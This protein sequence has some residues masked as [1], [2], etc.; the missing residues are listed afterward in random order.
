MTS[1]L[2]YGRNAV[3]EALRARRRTLRRLVVSRSVQESGIIADIIRLAEQAGI[4]IERIER[5]ILDRQLRDANHQGVML[6]TGPYPYVELDECL[7]SANARRE[8]ALLLLLDHLQD[9]QNL[10]TL[11]RTAE[12]V[13]CH[14]IIIPGRRAAE[15]TPAVVNASSGAVEHLR[16]AMVTN[17]SQ[18]IEELQHNGIWVV[19]LEQDETAQ[20]IDAVDLNL[21]LGLVIGAEGTGMSRLVR[22]RCD[23]LV[24]L[25]IVGQIGSLNAAVAGS[26]AIYHAWRQ[27]YRRYAE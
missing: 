20:D 26:I 19:G 27:R 6:E 16:V 24:R 7:S 14:G 9:P 5:Q 10:G 13:G 4:P 17:L 23:F 3:R 2:L 15:I 1:E 8:A 25:P 11:L 22:E 21:P 12:A 18:T